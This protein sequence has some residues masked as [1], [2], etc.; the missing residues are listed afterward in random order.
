MRNLRAWQAIKRHKHKTMFY[1]WIYD[2]FNQ[3]YLMNYLY[4]RYAEYELN[5]IQ[6]QV[7][8]RFIKEFWSGF[9]H[10][11][12]GRHWKIKTKIEMN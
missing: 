10:G 1:S 8:G 7:V 5:I 3:C 2:F 6:N 11:W 9:R 12:R 4:W